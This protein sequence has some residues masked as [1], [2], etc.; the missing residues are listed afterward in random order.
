LDYA[1]LRADAIA[2]VLGR[3]RT[4]CAPN[5]L[6]GRAGERLGPA[7]GN[8]ASGDRSLLLGNGEGWSKGK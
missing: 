1:V 2:T 3:N 6:H 5:H 8:D 4:G 7:F